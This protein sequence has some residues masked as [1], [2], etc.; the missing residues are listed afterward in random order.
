MMKINV[1][2]V[3]QRLFW[4]V[5]A[6][7]LMLGSRET[8]L[9]GRASTVKDAREAWLGLEKSSYSAQLRITGSQNHVVETAEDRDRNGSYDFWT[10][11]MNNEDPALHVLYTTESGVCGYLSVEMCG[12]NCASIFYPDPTCAPAD[13]FSVVC[14]TDQSAKKERTCYYYDYDQD[15]EVDAYK[16]EI[17]GSATLWHIEYQDS[18]VPLSAGPHFEQGEWIAQSSDSKVVY[19]FYTHL[20]WKER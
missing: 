10:I 14:L 16:T 17:S 8:W 12:G 6:A 11:E 2:K 13:A 19:I 4:G 15:S 18:L 3:L 20:G 1:P 5:L 7:G 9:I